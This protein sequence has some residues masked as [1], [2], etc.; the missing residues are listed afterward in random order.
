MR[1][2]MLTLGL[3]VF[4]AHLLTACPGD[5]NTGTRNGEPGSGGSTSGQ[6]GASGAAGAAGSAAASSGG[7]DG[8]STSTSGGAG[9]S[10]G[11]PPV[12]GSAGGGTG[13]A[14]GGSGGGSPLLAIA[15]GRNLDSGKD[16]LISIAEDETGA[17][18][19]SDVQSFAISPDAKTIAY[20]KSDRLFTMP[21]A[22]GPPSQVATLDEFRRDSLMEWSQDSSCIALTTTDAQ[23]DL[24]LRVL[25]VDGG[26][27]DHSI[28]LGGVSSIRELWVAPDCGHVAFKDQFPQFRGRIE[29]ASVQANATPVEL[30][31]D[32]WKFEYGA[33]NKV[34]FAD[35][36]GVLSADINGTNIQRIASA[37]NRFWLS[38]DGRHAAYRVLNGNDVELKHVKLDGTGVVDVH[39]T[40]APGGDVWRAEQFWSPDGTKLAYVADQDVDDQRELYVS[41]ADGTGNMKLSGTL[42]PDQ[43]VRHR[44]GIARF[45]WSPDGN[46]IAYVADAETDEVQELFVVPADGSAAPRKVSGAMQPD[47]DIDS[48]S[49][50]VNRF[51]WSPDGTC[52][53]Y[54]ADQLADTVIQLFAV[55]ALSS[56]A[57]SLDWLPGNG[58]V[59]LPIDSDEEIRSVAVIG[60]SVVGV[61]HPKGLPVSRPSL[62]KAGPTGPR[63]LPMPNTPALSTYEKLGVLL[64]KVFNPTN[65]K[66]VD[67]LFPERKPHL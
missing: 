15:V 35:N 46:H 51:Q 9:G 37:L 36:V 54:W 29:I 33:D 48:E 4:A 56:V 19:D 14:Q 16:E 17:T 62:R 22:G 23:G 58:L 65:P 11:S 67:I 10:S 13:G 30:S 12:G 61:A 31:T 43:D 25:D 41:N 24:A 32:G 21:T 55:S 8:G 59:G 52:L 40:L 5:E 42:G 18:L 20:A 63:R 28:G 2:R 53:L 60:D 34:V 39:P 1:D 57:C 49:D 38:P 47:G 27:F 64:G 45:L 66:L 50:R 44:D 7:S 26:T 6:G 3:A